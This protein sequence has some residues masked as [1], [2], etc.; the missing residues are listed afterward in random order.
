MQ[1]I[2][3]QEPFFGTSMRTF[4]SQLGIVA[5]VASLAAPSVVAGQ[6]ADD[7]SLAVVS[8]LLPAPT[9]GETS[10]VVTL[11]IEN[12]G[13]APAPASVVSVAPRNHLSLARRSTI[14]LLVPG[15]RTT[16]QLPVEIGPD[17]TPC[18][19]IT[20]TAIPTVDPAIAR[21]LAAVIPDPQIGTS[22][23]GDVASIDSWAG[24]SPLGDINRSEYFGGLSDW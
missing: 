10:D 7:Y 2:L 21:F 11:V 17:G 12:R 3:N 19:S 20:I 23:W 8:A 18:I 16:V 5:V 13:T 1:P 6:R 9:A 15:Q 14:P 24:F 4:G 22:S